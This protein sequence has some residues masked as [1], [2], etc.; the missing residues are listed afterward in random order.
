VG[1]FRDLLGPSKEEI[2]GLFAEQVHGQ[3][4]SDG[5]FDKKVVANVAHWTLTLDTLNGNRNHLTRMRAPYIRTDHFQFSIQPVGVMATIARA[6]G[7]NGISIGDQRFDDCFVIASNDESKM[8]QFL[9]DTLKGLLYAQIDGSFYIGTKTYDGWYQKDLPENVIEIYFERMGPMKDL[10]ELR[11][12]Y[13][14]F[15]YVLSRL[16]KIGSASENDP[17][18]NL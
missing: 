3:L 1:F 9:D 14:L 13:D 7:V 5:F 8:R 11:G 6:M 16:C 2:W 10:K 4:T 15:S 12:L 17:H 18:V